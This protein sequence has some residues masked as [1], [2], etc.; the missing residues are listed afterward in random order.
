[1]NLS[2]R[3][4]T[5]VAAFVTAF[6]AVS[7]GEARETF[8][9]VVPL[10]AGGTFEIDNKNGSIT[11]KT[12]NE[13]NVR[14]EAE[15]VAK[16]QDALDDIEID[17]QGSGDSVRVETHHPRNR[18]WGGGGKVSYV[19]TVPSEANVRASTANGSL[20]IDGVQGKV[21]ASSV[22]GSVKVADVVGVMD[23]STTNGS[24]RADYARALDGRH[25]F[26]T[27]NGSV[28]VYLPNDAGGDFDAKTVNGRIE[29]DFP[30]NLTSSGRRHQRGSFGS[31]G[32]SFDIRTVN[33]SVKILQN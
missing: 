15:K 33:G 25:R 26:K 7:F 31:G 13:G 11:I 3:T 27:T 19:I 1:M 18:L 23:V 32:G 16:T 9:E 17:I 30:T 2:T 24:I 8:E 5:T 21:D 29:V 20:T 4:A 28:R 14:I 10:S 22:N 6:A 12:W